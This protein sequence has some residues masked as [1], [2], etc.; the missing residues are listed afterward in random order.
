[1]VEPLK[2]ATRRMRPMAAQPVVSSDTPL[3]FAEATVLER[4]FGWR[5]GWPTPC[6]VCFRSR[7]HDNVHH[8]SDVVRRGDR[9]DCRPHRR[10][11]L[12]GLL[13]VH[14]RCDAR[15]GVAPCRPPQSYRADLAAGA[16]IALLQWWRDRT[17][18][19]VRV[20]LVLCILYSRR[21]GFAQQAASPDLHRVDHT[22]PKGCGRT[23]AAQE[24][25]ERFEGAA[26]DDR[27]QRT[28]TSSREL[29]HRRGLDPPDLATAGM[30]STTVLRTPPWPCRESLQRRAG[31]RGAASGT[32]SPD[33]GRPGLRQTICR[34]PLA[35]ARL[36]RLRE[37]LSL[38]NT[39]VFGLATVKATSGCR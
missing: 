35:S 10:P 22:Q 9:R 38:S 24:G 28:V 13:G 1:M 16:A 39:D 37:L 5:K 26:S 29:D 2:L 27:S 14:A 12:V 4:H 3:P 19:R 21:P 6:V 7:L 17:P 30:C 31:E 23:S 34:S 32:R 8:V 18:S 11:S 20:L 33:A 36:E 25:G 15:W